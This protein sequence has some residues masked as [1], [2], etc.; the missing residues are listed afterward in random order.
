MSYSR[1]V[2]ADKEHVCPWTTVEG[3]DAIRLYTFLFEPDTV[4]QGEYRILFRL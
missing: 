2:R 4:A 3:T 1:D